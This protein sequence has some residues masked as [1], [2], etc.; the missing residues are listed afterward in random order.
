M[1]RRAGGGS[2]GSMTDDTRERKGLNRRE[3]FAGAS[4]AGVALAATE[5]ATAQTGGADARKPVPPTDQRLARE[6]PVVADYT[7]DEEA[8]YFVAHPASD[9]MVDVIKSL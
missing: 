2:G 3:F 7:P 8:R 6:Q 9:V 4:A 5:Q 1:R